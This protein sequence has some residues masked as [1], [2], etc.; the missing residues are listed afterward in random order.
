[1]YIRKRGQFYHFE[2]FV[3]GK[4]YAGSFNGKNGSHFA[5]DK[6]EARELAY[7]ERRKVLDGTYREDV[8]RD[9]LKNFVTFVDKIYLPFAREHHASPAH[10]SFRCE[11]LKDYFKGKRFDEITMM[12]VVKFINQRLCSET[13]RKEALENGTVVNS[14]RSPTTVNK[15][16]TLLSSI[17]RLAI[18]ERVATANACDELPKSVRAKIPARRR[19][20]RRLSPVEENALF[21]VGLMGRRK[22][23]RSLTEAA[24]CTGMRKGE[25][26]RL[27]PEDLNFASET[28]TRIVKGEVWEVH[29]NWL[30]IE[31]SKNGRPRAI[32]MSQRVC[33]IL[34]M[35]SEDATAGEYVF[36][37]IRTGSQI[38]DIKKGFV[39]ACQEAKIINLTFHDL[40]HTWS[41]R[42]AEMGVPQHVRRD[43]LGHSSTSMTGDYT[44]A[45]PEEMERAMELVAAYKGQSF[46]NLGKISANQKTMA[47]QRSAI[48]L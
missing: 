36:S 47:D 19:R 21:N 32:P 27:R 34:Q 29:P 11:V 10:D 2:F 25:L 30:L 26:F 45:S 8:E 22:H 38:H 9:D 20:N 46:L 33:R 40:R 12:M 1:M 37:S 4:R 3:N 17:F 14:K 39:S 35:L 23:L 44:H 43:I 6:R 18:R 31:K 5:D 41:S 48:A 24:L 42:A 13:V 7:Q 15:E 16:V 28:V